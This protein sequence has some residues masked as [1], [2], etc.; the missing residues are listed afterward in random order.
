MIAEEQVKAFLI[1]S[2]VGL[3]TLFIC[4]PVQAVSTYTTLDVPGG[5]S[6]LRLRHRRAPEGSHI[7]ATRG[8][9]ARPDGHGGTARTETIDK[10]HGSLREIFVGKCQIPERTISA[11]RLFFGD[12]FH[13]LS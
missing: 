11:E 12:G 8:P 6:Y 9:R 13:D 4:V 2:V 5:N 7:L 10:A 1:S 3:V